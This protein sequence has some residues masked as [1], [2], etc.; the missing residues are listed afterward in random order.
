MREHLYPSRVPPALNLPS[1]CSDGAEKVS[2]GPV[3]STT[4]HVAY[5]HTH[6]HTHTHTRRERTLPTPAHIHTRALHTHRCSSAIKTKKIASAHTFSPPFIKTQ[7]NKN[8]KKLTTSCRQEG[9]KQH[10]WDHY[11]QA[12]F[13]SI[14]FED[15]TEESIY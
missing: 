5:T 7:K 3:H 10:S 1:I 15:M 11:I 14:F 12:S 9:L 4:H 8:K 13:F 2:S 6:T